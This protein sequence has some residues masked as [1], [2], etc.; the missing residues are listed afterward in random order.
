MS[1][2]A[3]APPSARTPLLLACGGSFLAFLDAMITN[4]AVPDLAHDFEVGV[5]SVSW[6]VTIYAIPLAALLAPAGRLADVLG[7]RRLFLIG[8]A[9]FTAASLLVA[10]APVFAA[11]L[12]GRAAQGVGAALLIPASFAIVLADTAPERRA[13]AIALWSASASLAAVLGPVVGGVLVDAVGW[14]VLFCV[15]VPLGI[16]LLA[17]ARQLPTATPTPTPTPAHTQ[18]AATQRGRFPDA[19]ATALLTGGIAALVLG[20][21]EAERWGWADPATLACLIGGGA[22]TLVAIGRSAG[23]PSPA[24]EVG[25]WRNRTYAAANAVSALFGAFLFASLLLGVLFLVSVWDYSALR[26]GLAM[27]PGAVFSALVGITISRS[28]RQASP[29]VLVVAGALTLAATAGALALWLPAEPSFLTAWLPG[30]FGLG[31]GIGAI[32]VGSSSAAALSVDPTRFAAA[33]GLNIAARQ[34]GGALGIAAL[35]ML[36]ESRAG[37]DPLTPYEHIYWLMAA[38]SFAAAGAGLLLRPN[39]PETT[40][41]PTPPPA[42]PSPSPSPS[43]EAA[44]ASM[45]TPPP[46][47]NLADTRP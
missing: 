4:L 6:V 40:T 8:A 23:H 32:S 19:T 25:L 39:R 10:V 9:V 31:L 14:R 20:L 2:R 45:P 35:A 7:R 26:A 18:T 5:T 34:I 16:W 21:T 13:A 17:R 47:Q 22:A 46:V 28:K 27:T 41:V 36:L 44:S 42:S 29:R 30:G 33:V 11:L 37:S 38:L 15:N 43:V 24:I 3:P 1:S 12:V